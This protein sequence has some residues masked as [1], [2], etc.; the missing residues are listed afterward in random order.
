M[1]VVV[2]RIL[3][4]SEKRVTETRVPTLCP[5]GKQSCTNCTSM[6]FITK[7]N[8]YC[9]DG[10]FGLKR[11]EPQMRYK[12]SGITHIVATG[13]IENVNENSNPDIHHASAYESNFT[14]ISMS[15]ADMTYINLIERVCDS[16]RVDFDKFMRVLSRE[17]KKEGVQISKYKFFNEKI[18]EANIKN[19]CRSQMTLF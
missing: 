17:A 4:R 2:E 6:H 19:S 16:L 10:V 13:V 14:K 7:K 9:Y 1:S 12:T 15:G 11:Q 18:Q 3:S 8:R 5:I